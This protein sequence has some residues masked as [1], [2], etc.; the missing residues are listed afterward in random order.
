MTIEEWERISNSHSSAIIAP[1]G[2]GK[3]EMIADIVDRTSGKSLLLTHTNAGVDALSKRMAKKGI[4]TNKYKVE[5]IASFCIKWCCAYCNTANIDLTLSPYNGK[6]ETKRY[7]D[8]YYVGAKLLFEN[9]W[10]CNILKTTYSRIVVDEYQDCTIKHHE[11]FRELEKHLPIVVLGDP[12]QG[13][14][15]FTDTLVDW[16]N[17]EFPIVDVV[18]YPWRWKNT[19]PELGKYLLSVRKQLLPA[20]ANK[21]CKVNLDSNPSVTVI[22]PNGF[23]MYSILQDLK[24]YNSVIYVTKWEA[25]QIDLCTKLGGLFQNDE[26]QECPELFNYANRFD[27]SKACE[28]AIQ[29]LLFLKVCATNVTKEL[30]SYLDRLKKDNM[31][32]SRISKHKEIGILIEKVCSSSSLNDIYSLIKEFSEINCFKIYRKELYFEMLR[33]IKYAIE[34]NTTIYDSANHI[35]KDVHLQRHYTQFKYLSSRT[36]LSKGLEFDCVIID[37]Q[38]KLSAKDFYVAMT[39]A[40]KKIYVISSSKQILFN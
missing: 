9:A 35:R 13:I 25:Q 8:Q 24:K 14:F 3:T 6:E 12:M 17:L 11:I 26:K 33:S 36:L 20:L 4:N 40:M 28:L 23:N 30:K 10:A 2:H 32:F 19:N 5:T 7:Y 34:H 21:P 16:N 22:S 39:R 29:I 38:N 27:H 1:A 18:T 15:G 37:M 31:D